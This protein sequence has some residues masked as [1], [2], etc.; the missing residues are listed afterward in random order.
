M[1]FF[2]LNLDGRV[3]FVFL[4]A[5]LGTFFCSNRVGSLAGGPWQCLSATRSPHGVLSCVRIREL[6]TTHLLR[7]NFTLVKEPA[8]DLIGGLHLTPYKQ[9]TCSPSLPPT[10]PTIPLCPGA[11]PRR[12]GVQA[13]KKTFKATLEAVIS[14]SAPSFIQTTPI[15]PILT[16]RQIITTD[17]NS[18][19]KP[20]RRYGTYEYE[21]WAAEVRNV[22]LANGVWHYVTD[23]ESRP[24]PSF[25]Q[26][27]K[28]WES[29]DALARLIIRHF[30]DDYLAVLVSC[31][32][33]SRM[34][35]S[36]LELRVLKIYV[37]SGRESPRNPEDS[38]DNSCLEYIEVHC[39]KNAGVLP[40]VAADTLRFASRRDYRAGAEADGEFCSRLEVA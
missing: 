37:F 21:I 5:V 39:L 6:A 12:L 13:K 40:K 9:L 26:R 23:H 2:S 17:F 29:K 28:E 4:V 18:N 38:E 31:L 34:M 19:I 1:S 15:V 11:T 8:V 24:D 3:S 30:L 20:L 25:T 22:L 35:W 33:T 27:L 10:T 14:R 16:S 32:D 36:F 7:P